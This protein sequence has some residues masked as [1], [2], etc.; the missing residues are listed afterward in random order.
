MSQKP[1][2]ASTRLPGIIAFK[3]A[4]SPPR[5]FWP[6]I[7][8]PASPKPR[9]R[10]EPILMMVFSRTTVS[11]GSGMGLGEEPRRLMHLQMAA[12]HR[13]QSF[14]RVASASWSAGPCC[15]PRFRAR[16]CSRWCSSSPIVMASRG[17]FRIL[18]NFEIIRS[19]G[20]K[21]SRLASWEKVM[22]PK[23]SRKQMKHVCAVFRIASSHVPVLRSKTKMKCRSSYSAAVAVMG[24]MTV[25]SL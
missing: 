1:K 23:P 10:S 19:M 21:T 4:E 8:A 20:V 18:S 17:L 2:I 14:F 12:Q 16:T 11:M 24:T 3:A 7:S 6:I 25:R 13:L 9:A 22:A 5:M 15:C